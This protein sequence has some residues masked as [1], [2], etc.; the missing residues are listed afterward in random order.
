MS[1]VNFVQVSS[2]SR[3]Q[4]DANLGRCEPRLPVLRLWAGRLHA[5]ADGSWPL[6]AT[7]R[8]IL[9]ML[10]C[11]AKWTDP[12]RESV[13]DLAAGWQALLSLPAA[14]AAGAAAA[15][16]ASTPALR[17][18]NAECSAARA[19]SSTATTTT[20]V[21]R[22]RTHQAATAFS[23]ASYQASDGSDSERRPFL[24]RRA[25]PAVPHSL[26]APAP[27]CR[28]RPNTK[29]IGVEPAAVDTLRRSL[30]I[31]KPVELPDDA[32]PSKMMRIDGLYVQSPSEGYVY[33]IFH[34]P[35]SAP[36]RRF[37]ERALN[38]SCW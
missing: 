36:Q 32:D 37:A 16:A 22:S 5:C 13:T 8:A 31:G 14:R 27:F 34:S 9:L 30:G 28:G 35:S 11:C 15:T 10:G 26:T 38:T 3:Q 24:T 6:A 33:H 21:S 12:M 20:C 18:R 23:M 2:H 29:V 19:L 4:R 1:Q 7:A 17:A 25:P